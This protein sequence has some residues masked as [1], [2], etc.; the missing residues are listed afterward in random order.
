MIKEDK[1]KENRSTRKT[2]LRNEKGKNTVENGKRQI[3]GGKRK[4]EGKES[5]TRERRKNS[6][7]VKEYRR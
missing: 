6:E 1:K 5:R 2:G 3:G 7:K 4:T